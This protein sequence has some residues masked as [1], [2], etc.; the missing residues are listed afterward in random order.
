MNL[1][2][3]AFCQCSKRATVAVKELNILFLFE[4][5][6]SQIGKIYRKYSQLELKN[7]KNYEENMREFRRKYLKRSQSS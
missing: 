2:K 6:N 5:T 7:R 1:K 4:I 3:I